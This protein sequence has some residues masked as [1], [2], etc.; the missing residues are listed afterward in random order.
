MHSTSLRAWCR[1]HSV[2]QP[3][4]HPAIKYSTHA[5]PSPVLCTKSPTPVTILIAPTTCTPW[6]KQTQFPTWTRIE[7][8]QPKCPRS[9][10]KPWHVNDSSHIKPSYWPLGFSISLLTSTLITKSTTFEIWIQDPWSTARRPK[11]Q[12]IAQEGHP[13]EGKTA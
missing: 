4:D 6:D 10:F 8:K 5:W 2:I 9:E 13:E 1:S 7:V 3:P 12:I 11:S